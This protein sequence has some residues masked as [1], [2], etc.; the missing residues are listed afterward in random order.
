MPTAN[1]LSARSKKRSRSNDVI[2]EASLRSVIQSYLALTIREK[3]T[4]V[5]ATKAHCPSPAWRTT[6]W[7]WSR[8]PRWLL[9]Y[10]IERRRDSGTLFNLR[11]STWVIMASPITLMFPCRVAIHSSEHLRANNAIFEFW[12]YSLKH[13]QLWYCHG[14][15]WD[16]L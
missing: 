12:V 9:S 14:M 4:K 10:Y 1:G 8:A 16:V 5:L 13:T 6:C 7:W 2:G 11:V 15:E 3:I